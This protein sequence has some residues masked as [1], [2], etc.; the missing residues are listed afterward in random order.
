MSRTG[1]PLPMVLPIWEHD[2]SEFPDVVRVSME[3][4]HV[5]NYRRE[6]SQPKPV[7][8]EMLDRFTTTCVGYRAKRRRRG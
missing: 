4:G 6:I 2:W 5:I 7:F 3:D 1:K 8:K